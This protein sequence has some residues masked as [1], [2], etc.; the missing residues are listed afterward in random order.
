M[1][2]VKILTNERSDKN[3]WVVVQ[4]EEIASGIH[5]INFRLKYDLRGRPESE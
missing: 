4:V 2:T 3:I 5:P 1:F